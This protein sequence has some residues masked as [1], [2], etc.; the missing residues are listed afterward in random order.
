MARIEFDDVAH[1][2]LRNPKK[3][4]DFAIKTINNGLGRR[5]R[6][7]AAGAFGLR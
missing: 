3:E 1:S 6:L 2:Y 4:S 7:C 5:R